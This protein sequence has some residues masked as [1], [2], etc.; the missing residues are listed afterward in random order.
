MVN[1]KM[2]KE[3]QRTELIRA[4][5]FNGSQEMIKNYDLQSIDYDIKET[6]FGPIAIELSKRRPRYFIKS[7]EEFL[8]L[9]IGDWIVTGANGEHWAIRDKV[10]RK[11]YVEVK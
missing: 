4:E 7:L 9:K 11:K 6:R 1:R 8:E 3:Y 10:F 5:Q 2:I